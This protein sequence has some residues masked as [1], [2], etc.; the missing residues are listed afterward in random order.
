MDTYRSTHADNMRLHELQVQED[1]T[2]LA[3]HYERLLWSTGGGPKYS[4][5]FLGTHKLGVEEWAGQ[6]SDETTGTGE[7]P[8]DFRRR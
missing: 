5:M 6:A 7:G 8:I 4:Q 1:I 3:Q 2:K